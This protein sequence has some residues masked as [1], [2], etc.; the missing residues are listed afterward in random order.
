MKIE[1]RRLQSNRRSAFMYLPYTWLQE[2]GIK[3]GDEVVVSIEEDKISVRPA[4]IHQD[5]QPATN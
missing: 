3:G 5:T 1:H 4:T 2:H